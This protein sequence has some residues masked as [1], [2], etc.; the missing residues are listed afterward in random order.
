LGMLLGWTIPL[1]LLIYSIRGFRWLVAL[2]MC[3]T[4]SRFWQSLCANA[5][6]AGLAVV[7]PFK[8]GEAIKVRLLPDQSGAEWRQGVSGFLLERL[9]DLLGLVGT[10]I[11]GALF[12]FGFYWLSPLSL[13]LPLLAGL[14][15]RML[16]GHVH[17]T[18]PRL[19][20]YL[21]AFSDTRRV[22]G[23]ALLSI[24]LWLGYAFLWWGAVRSMGVMVGFG[25]ITLVLGGAV[26]AVAASLVPGGLGVSELSI[27]GILIWLGAAVPEAE[28][29]AIGVRL[30]TPIL[31]VFGVFCLVPLTLYRRHQGGR[32]LKSPAD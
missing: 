17:R 24:P 7:T 10:G 29:A 21:D 4:F 32:F 9:M 1:L 2:G 28:A 11:F 6:A 19:G 23:T 14:T 16:G 3:F 18:F 15:L 8:A 13:L 30:L 20:R 31:V 22:V 5:A 12:H 25:E 27:R 26:L